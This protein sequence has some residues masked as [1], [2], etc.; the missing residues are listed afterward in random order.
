MDRE[1]LHARLRRAL[2]FAGDTHT[3]EDV[4]QGVRQGRLQAWTQGDSFVV[5]TITRSPQRAYLDVFLA[6]GS[7][8]EVMS[9][10]PKLEDFAKAHGLHALRMIGRKGWR[11]V[12]PS[13]GWHEREAVVYEREI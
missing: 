8:D 9:L 4:V 11:K 6:V 10:Q 5:T 12:L 7:L 2:A 13:F 3:V 1:A